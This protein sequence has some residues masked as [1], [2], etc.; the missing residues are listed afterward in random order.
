MLTKFDDYP[1]HQTSEPLAIP[2]TTDRHA[3]DRYW[4]NGYQDDGAF[5]FGIGAAVYPNLGIVD[6]ALSIVHD[7]EQHAFHASRRA[8][9]ERSEIE[10]GPFKIEIIQPMHSLRVTLDDNETGIA[11]DLLWI[12]RTA[13]FAEEFQRSKRTPNRSSVHME[14]TRFNQFGRWQ[15]EIRYAGK[16]VRVDPDRVY[17]TKDR[18][19]G[20]RP[21]GDPAP[22]GAPPTEL[23]CINFLWA[24][25]HWK[26][27]CTHAG[28]FQNEHGVTWHW[29]GMIM[30]TYE[31]PDDI[32]GVEDPAMVPLAGVDHAIQ[33]FH[34]GTR[35]ARR[36]TVSL[37]DLE[38]GRT[39]IDLEALLV[40]RMKGIGYSHPEWGH[41][42]WKGELAM[43]GESWKI[44]E[45]DDM[46][47]PNQHIQQVV[48]ARIGEE[49]GVG[50]LEQI[51]MGPSKRY[52]FKE[53][54]D[55]AS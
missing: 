54:L 24:P 2:A 35:R 29:D 52:G 20:I 1:I 11:A 48:R 10:V 27:R 21:V 8:P 18:S 49:E 6:C 17:G 16:A 43:A 38:G 22:P 51:H 9:A 31:N 34:P 12:P 36:A 5:Y 15:G 23:P 13:S 19:W 30:P 7:G 14:A 37:L 44:E 33:E 4:F 40:F 32:P 42:R 46:Q 50:V 45:C 26:D 53:F 55:P 3:Y 25:L 41:G 47:L 28:L 39:D